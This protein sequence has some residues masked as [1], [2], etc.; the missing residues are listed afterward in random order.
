MEKLEILEV[1]NDWNYWNR[2]LPSIVPRSAYDEKIASFLQ[3]DEV[4]V[5][6]GIRRCGKSTLLLTDVTINPNRKFS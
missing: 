2:E 3:K 1:L 4:I 6:K 5:L